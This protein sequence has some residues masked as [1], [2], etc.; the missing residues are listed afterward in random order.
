MNFPSRRT[1]LAGFCALTGSSAAWSEP[2]SAADPPLFQTASSQFTLVEP[3]VALPEIRIERI[4]GELVDLALFRGKAVLV[5]FWASWC[6]PCARELPLLERL[7]D[8][9]RSEP[10]E[11]VAASIDADGRDTVKAFLKRRRIERLPVYLDPA[12]RLAKNVDEDRAAPFTLYGL[13]M[14]YVIDRESRIAGY[15]AGAADWSSA[16]GLALLRYY[17]TL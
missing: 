6:P 3:A 11:I 13:P 12:R 7:R 1:V 14:S 2:L 5:N 9:A 10:L 16:E 8:I 15:L 4:D 17:M